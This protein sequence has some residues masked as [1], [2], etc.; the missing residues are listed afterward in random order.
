M[1]P[2]P[3]PPAPPALTLAGVRAAGARLLKALAL[4]WQSS[5]SATITLGALTLGSAA[6]PLMVAYAAKRI[7]DAIVAHDR[8]AALRWV[9]L[10]L[11]AVVVLLLLGRGLVLVRS[12]LGARLSVDINVRILEKALSLD[13]AHFED[14]TTY[15][16]LQRA[17]REASSRPVATITDGFQLLQNALQFLGYA[18]LLVGFNP[19]ILVGL[20]AAAV[21]ATVAE[22]TFSKAAFRVRN[23]RSPEARRLNYLEYVLAND[24]HVKEIKLFDLGPLLLS[25][26]R[27]LG[28]LF[29]VEDR[30]LAVRRAGWGAALTL[31]GTVALYVCYGMM[32]GSAAAGLLSLGNVTLYMVALRQGQQSFQAALGAV[33]SVYENSLYISSLFEFFAIPTERQSLP[34]SAAPSTAVADLPSTAV[35]DSP[36]TAVAGSPSMAVSGSPSE[37]GI[38]FENAGFR[39]PNREEWAL[40]GVDLFIPEGQS[41]ALVGHN[42]AGKTTIIKLLAGLYEP[43]EGRV[44]LDGRDL[45]SWEPAA[46]RRRIG[47]IFQDFNRYQ[48]S[49]RENVAFGDTRRLDDDA[50]VDVAVSQGGAEAVVASLRQGLDTGL[51]HWFKG[52]VELSGG[53][54][55]K[56]ALARAFMRTEADILVLDEPTAALDAE[57]EH[58]VFERFRALTQG[59]TTLLISQRFPT[60]RMADRI[61]VLD[62]GRVV[63]DGTH[64]ELVAANARYAQL[65]ALQARGYL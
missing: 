23:W 35:A 59:R 37:R 52:G 40:R 31:V 7:I 30:K 16:L 43:S 6:L 61:L 46:L 38:R 21:P 29:D 45:R 63:E 28:E 57:A 4:V 58:A 41:I 56:V 12:L 55:Q 34:V 11:L 20:V 32:A 60:V 47:V 24:G 22:M 9:A 54:W 33:N 14:S 19:W 48:L 53:Q 51:G 17:R 25:R 62:A 44:L 50:A 15:D 5:P 13:L 3:L 8:D 49:L 26:F 1:S 65:F 36:S 42:G 18:G 64:A 27:G 2:P 10:E 39:Y